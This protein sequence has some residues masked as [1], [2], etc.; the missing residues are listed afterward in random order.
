MFLC[1]LFMLNIM[2]IYVYIVNGG[3]LFVFMRIYVYI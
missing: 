1:I 2:C 3:Y